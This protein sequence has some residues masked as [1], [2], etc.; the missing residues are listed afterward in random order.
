MSHRNA[1]TTV[2]GRL[3]IFQRPQDG[4]AQADVAAP[5]TTAR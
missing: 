5:G 2:P 4:W 3:L 1:R